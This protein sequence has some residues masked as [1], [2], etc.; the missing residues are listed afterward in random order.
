MFELHIATKFF[1][2]SDWQT[3]EKSSLFHMPW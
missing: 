3:G 2:I 1:N